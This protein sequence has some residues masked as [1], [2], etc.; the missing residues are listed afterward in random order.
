MLDVITTDNLSSPFSGELVQNKE[1]AIAS[2]QKFW[3]LMLLA[4]NLLVKL[5]QTE[6]VA[7]FA[8]TL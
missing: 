3:V 6:M 8:Q 1:L 5:P 4:T 2:S 7:E